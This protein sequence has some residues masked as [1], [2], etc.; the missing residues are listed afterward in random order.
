ML[1]ANEQEQGQHLL[2]TSQIGSLVRALSRARVA[3]L[4][5]T[6]THILGIIVGAVMVHSGN[7]F[8]LSYRDDLVGRAQS[9]SPL[10][11]LHEGAPVRAALLDFAGNA[12]AAYANMLGGLGV[13]VPYPVTAYR[14]W[15]GGVSYRWTAVT[16]AGWRVSEKGLIT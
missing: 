2:T 1:R 12:F 11:A 16:P 4:T 8:A 9:N 15:V 5:I 3:I 13:I 6:A 7:E 14:G 10:A